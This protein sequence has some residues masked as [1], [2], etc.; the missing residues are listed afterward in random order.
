MVL[1]AITYLLLDADL[2][3]ITSGWFLRGELVLGMEFK[4]L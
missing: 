1:V 3:I 4:S 2:K